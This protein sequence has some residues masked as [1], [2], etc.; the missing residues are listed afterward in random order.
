MSHHLTFFFPRKDAKHKK[1]WKAAWQ[2]NGNACRL[3]RSR[4]TRFT[5]FESHSILSVTDKVEGCPVPYC[6]DLPK[7]KVI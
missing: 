3:S 7:K 1:K 5:S 4:T 2:M 6:R